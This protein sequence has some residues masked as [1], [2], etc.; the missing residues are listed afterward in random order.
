MIRHD[1]ASRP[2]RGALSEYDVARMAGYAFSTWRK[3]KPDVRATFKAHVPSLTLPEDRLDAYDP[4]QVAAY[5][6]PGVT[7]PSLIVRDEDLADEEKH[8]DDLLSDHE[9]ARARGID[10]KSIQRGVRSGQYTGHLEIAGIRWWPRHT[11]T[12]KQA[13]RPQGA[14]DSAPR[15]LCHHPVHDTADAR[16]NEIA[17]Q[18][19]DGATA[20]VK[21]IALRYDVAEETALRYIRRARRRAGLPDEA[22]R[23][24]RNAVHQVVQEV[25][26]W[27]AN[28]QDV[29]P[30]DIREQFGLSNTTC[31]RVL[32]RAREAH[33]KT[34][35]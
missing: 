29:R 19:R 24:S 22:Q 27:L 8:P 11:L 35:S 1:R 17:E 33:R 3:K 13:G 31:H 12:P 23:A 7:M 4:E 20:T 14:T 5:F 25:A 16:V 28:G 26:G 34:D 18:F 32:E 21:E 10:V 6:T 15:A 9:A 30:R 2:D